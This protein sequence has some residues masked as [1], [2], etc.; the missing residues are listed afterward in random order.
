[1]TRVCWLQ[2]CVRVVA[3]EHARRIAVVY[4]AE[5]L[6]DRAQTGEVDANLWAN[7]PRGA[8]PNRHDEEESNQLNTAA[9]LTVASLQRTA[10]LQPWTDVLR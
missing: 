9:L 10:N 6:R 1:L 4:E 7:P 8:E 5:R 2:G 3:D